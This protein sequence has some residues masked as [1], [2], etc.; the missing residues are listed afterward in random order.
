MLKARVYQSKAIVHY[1][2]RQYR[3]LNGSRL[4]HLLVWFPPSLPY[5]TIPLPSQLYHISPRLS[6]LLS[7][8]L[9]SS[10]T[11]ILSLS[12]SLSRC[13]NLPRTLRLSSRC[14]S[15]SPPLGQALAYRSVGRSGPF[16][17][18]CLRSV[19]S[20]SHY[21]TVRPRRR[22]LQPYRVSAAES[23]RL[24]QCALDWIYR[25]EFLRRARAA[26]GMR[27]PAGKWER[28]P[29][30]W[31]PEEA[32]VSANLPMP[33]GT[34]VPRWLPVSCTLVIHFSSEFAAPSIGNINGR[35]TLATFRQD[36]R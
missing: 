15:R 23:L 30:N 36:S 22:V 6:V 8:S 20:V 12:L 18:V 35:W 16:F 24:P 21:A 25:R 3:L 29:A 14:R 4:C 26:A 1:V 10:S 9:L 32:K 13:I 33:R 19:S 17:L 31:S 27:A 11:L 34:I 28:P 5:V 2:W 7:V